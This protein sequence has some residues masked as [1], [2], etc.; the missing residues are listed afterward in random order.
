MLIKISSDG[1][2][3][4]PEEIIK[5][6]GVGPGDRLKLEKTEGDSLFARIV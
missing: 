5:Q 4:L 1:T 6:L 3:D 2:V